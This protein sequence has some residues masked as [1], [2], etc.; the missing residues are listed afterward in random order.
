MVDFA[1]PL[2]A[3]EVF[4]TAGGLSTMAFRYEDKIP[5][6]EYKTL[7][8]P[9]HA[10]LMEAIRA[11]GLLEMDPIPSAPFTARYLAAQAARSG[12]AVRH[13]RSDAP[14]GQRRPAL[15]DIPWTTPDT[16]KGEVMVDASEQDVLLRAAA[17]LTCLGYASETLPPRVF[18]RGS[19][20]KDWG[21]SKVGASDGD[22]ETRF[23]YLPD[24]Q[25][26]QSRIDISAQPKGW[27][28]AVPRT[29]SR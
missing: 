16:W 24:P 27:A 5:V 21:E 11:L 20:S 28:R 13:A 15:P 7:R 18:A 1:A 6:M 2:G 23:T 10:E 9:G 29:A 19:S 26:W 22:G 4:H 17:F 8:Y 3:L 14:P 12:S 25:I